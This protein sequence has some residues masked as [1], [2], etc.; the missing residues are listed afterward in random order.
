MKILL[1]FN[2]DLPM[3]RIHLL[4]SIFPA[5]CKNTPFQ[6]FYKTDYLFYSIFLY[7]IISFLDQTSSVFPDDKKWF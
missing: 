6:T 2:P 1:F 5:D 3:A 7:L 4:D